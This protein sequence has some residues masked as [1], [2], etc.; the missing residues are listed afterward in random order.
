HKAVVGILL[1]CVFWWQSCPAWDSILFNC[2]Y[3]EREY[4]LQWYKQYP[5]GQPEFMILPITLETEGNDNFEMTLDTNKK[6]TSLYLKNIQLK[7]S[8]VYFCAWSTVLE[9]QLL[10][11]TKVEDNP[12]KEIELPFFFV[13]RSEEH[14]ESQL[15]PNIFFQMATELS[16]LVFP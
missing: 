10:V 4:S 15:L 12:Q 16:L 1:S 13:G 6:T 5:G 3:Q 14:L 11:F 7:D 8:A 9:R 2:S